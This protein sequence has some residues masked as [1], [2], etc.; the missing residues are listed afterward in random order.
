M[1]QT[2]SRFRCPP[3][4]SILCE[5]YLLKLNTLYD[6]TS[7]IPV[8]PVARK[9]RIDTRSSILKYPLE[10]THLLPLIVE[11]HTVAIR[12]K[13]NFSHMETCSLFRDLELMVAHCH[14]THTFLSV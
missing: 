6:P 1:R 7:P 8:L 3:I 11:N 2:L 12:P 5:H 4:Y 13:N 10:L 9:D 14:L